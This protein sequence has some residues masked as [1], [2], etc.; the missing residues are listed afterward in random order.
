MPISLVIVFLFFEKKHKTG[1]WL[2]SPPLK[3]L[4]FKAINPFKFP[5][6]ALKL[7]K[8]ML[9]KENFKG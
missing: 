6:V 8:A 3:A 7:A 5:T 4:D 1:S 9:V 2:I